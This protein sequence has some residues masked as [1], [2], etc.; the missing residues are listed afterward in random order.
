M[1]AVLALADVHSWS[2]SATTWALTVLLVLATLVNEGI[3]RLEG[4]IA[5]RNGKS[6]RRRRT[7]K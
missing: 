1:A 6:W 5:K 2:S 3:W 7:A 4:R